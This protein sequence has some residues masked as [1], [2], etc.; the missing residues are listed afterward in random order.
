MDRSRPSISGGH[1]EHEDKRKDTV[2]ES[3]KVRKANSVRELL[4][5]LGL[6][7][8]PPVAAPPLVYPVFVANA[9]AQAGN[10][11]GAN[12]AEPPA[13]RPHRLN[14][15][16]RDRRRQGRSSCWNLFSFSQSRPSTNQ[17]IEV[18]DVDSHEVPTQTQLAKCDG[19]S[20]DLGAITPVTAQPSEPDRNGTIVRLRAGLDTV[21]A[22][23][24]DMRSRLDALAETLGPAI[25]ATSTPNGT[26]EN[27]GRGGRPASA[28]STELPQGG[29]YE[30]FQDDTSNGDPTSAYAKSPPERPLFQAHGISSGRTITAMMQAPQILVAD[31][32]TPKSTYRVA[33]G[34]AQRLGELIALARRIFDRSAE[35]YEVHVH[36]DASSCDGRAAEC[37]WDEGWFIHF[38]RWSLTEK[39]EMAKRRLGLGEEV[40]RSESEKELD[41]LR[42]VG[43]QTARAGKLWEAVWWWKMARKAEVRMQGERERGKNISERDV[44]KGSTPEL[45][46]ASKTGEG[47]TP[48][49]LPDFVKKEILEVVRDELSGAIQISLSER[50]KGEI[51]ETV[52]EGLLEILDDR[53]AEIVKSETRKTIDEE[54]VGCSASHRKRKRRVADEDDMNDVIPGDR[55]AS[56]QLPWT[57]YYPSQIPANPT[58]LQDVM[59]ID[60][61]ATN[62]YY[63]RDLIVGRALP[64]F[65]IDPN[66]RPL[67]RATLV[68][69]CQGSSLRYNVY[70]YIPSKYAKVDRSGELQIPHD[71][72]EFL[73]DFTGMTK[74]ERSAK[75][76]AALKEDSCEDADF[77]TIDTYT[78]T[79]FLDWD[80][81]IG[82]ARPEIC[83]D[84]QVRPLVR[85]TLSNDDRVCVFM[86]ARFG[87]DRNRSD[88]ELL[89]SIGNVQVW[90]EFDAPTDGKRREKIKE[91]LV[92]KSKE[93]FGKG[94]ARAGISGGIEETEAL[95]GGAVEEG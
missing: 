4:D 14:F 28:K 32:S 57:I 35:D 58:E 81:V 77:T 62:K 15:S 29:Q 61:Y 43:D 18:A 16:W 1:L 88:G 86:P 6:T 87:I 79:R 54:G 83:A 92:K 20:P 39:I 48:T 56:T 30:T 33:A 44:L 25:E 9:A 64:S 72:V 22:Q 26:A 53:M 76:V 23:V 71:Q 68:A 89:I 24:E 95:G 19:S 94:Y 91:A 3:H 51:A 49:G 78:G 85:A 82:H 8:A 74:Q 37:E 69:Q 66:V 50:V 5:N 11:S 40:Q 42:E 47:S 41:R 45:M 7:L 17:D 59:T 93:R 10:S 80:V 12:E 67:V 34:R 90:S 75:M 73:A 31:F 36:F 46:K 21:Q 27:R 38:E 65:C 52:K 2:S 84:P 60:A 70:T 13:A 55:L 63:S